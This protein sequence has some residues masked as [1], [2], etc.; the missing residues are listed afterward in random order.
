MFRI[1]RPKHVLNAGSQIHNYGPSFQDIHSRSA[2]Q[3]PS[4]LN[5]YPQCDIS[6]INQSGNMEFSRNNRVSTI[7]A[8]K[9][10]F[11]DVPLPESVVTEP[12]KTVPLSWKEALR[13]FTENTT[14]HGLRFIF[15]TDAFILRRYLYY[16][17]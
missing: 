14:M 9:T 10:D 13:E 4:Q 5:S 11:Q 17:A 3:S 16:I 2:C 1:P 8:S 12:V 7:S 15:M 6:R